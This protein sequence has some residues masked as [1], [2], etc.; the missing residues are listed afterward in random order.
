VGSKSTPKQRE[1]ASVW[2]VQVLVVPIEGLNERANDLARRGGDPVGCKRRGFVRDLGFVPTRTRTAHKPEV[3]GSK[4][5]VRGRPGWVGWGR[6]ENAN[7]LRDDDPDR[8]IFDDLRLDRENY[9]GISL[10]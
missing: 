4:G 7:R 10:A 2:A 5:Q 6:H 8:Q 9:L 3:L 1:S